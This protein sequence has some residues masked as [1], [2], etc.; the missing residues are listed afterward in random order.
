LLVPR[1]QGRPH[2]RLVPVLLH[3]AHDPIVGLPRLLL[4]LHAEAALSAIHIQSL[5]RR[6]LRDI[7]PISAVQ[8]VQQI[9]VQGATRLRIFLV[10]VADVHE[11]GS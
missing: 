8:V 4:P 5:P 3:L 7:V 1:P 6:L 2:F 9:L 11:L 10:P